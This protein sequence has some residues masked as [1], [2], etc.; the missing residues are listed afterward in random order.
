MAKTVA[1]QLVVCVVN[2]GK[3]NGTA[4]TFFRPCKTSDGKFG[5][6]PD[7]SYN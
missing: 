4:N 5:S 1:K 2:D 6:R 7:D 3:K